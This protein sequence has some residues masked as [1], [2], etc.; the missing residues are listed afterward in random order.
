MAL[1]KDEFDDAKFGEWAIQTGI[2]SEDELEEGLRIQKRLEKEFGEHWNIGEILYR[3]GFITRAQV[4]Q[5]LHEQGQVAK[6]RIPGYE[7]RSKIGQGSTAAVFE[8]LQISTQTT[9]ALKILLPSLTR[10]ERYVERFLAESQAATRLN[11]PNIISCLDAGRHADHCY[12]AMEFVK[13]E[14]LASVIRKLGTLDDWRALG[15]TLKM[16]AALNHAHEQGIIHR[17]IKP[18]NIF[19]TPKGDARLA[20]FSLARATFTPD[21]GA[22]QHGWTVGT[23]NYMSPEQARGEEADG[24]SDIYSLGATLFHMLTGSPPYT[25]NNAADIMTKVVKGPFEWPPRAR[26]DVPE[27]IV[28]LVEKAMAYDTRDRYQSF[29]EFVQDISAIV[30]GSNPFVNRMPRRR[31]GRSGIR[32]RGRRLPPVR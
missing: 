2:I 30:G 15:I 32:Y 14:T 18:Q 16:C 19:I 22:T 5:I 10:D 9:V 4:R 29:V 28:Q 25:G 23:A 20:D 12:L 13:G 7:V 6:T 26:R 21:R 31:P 11:H 27:P 1:Q 8:A 17:D 3:K 24:R